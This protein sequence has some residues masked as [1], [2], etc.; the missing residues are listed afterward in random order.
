MPIIGHPS[1]TLFGQSSLFLSTRPLQI[2]SATRSQLL[3]TLFFFGRPRV[4]LRWQRRRTDRIVRT[5]F[6][7]GGHVGPTSDGY[8]LPIINRRGKGSRA[9]A[10]GDLAMGACRGEDGHL[11]MRACRGEDEVDSPV[12]AVP[13]HQTDRVSFGRLGRWRQRRVG[14]VA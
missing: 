12:L 7:H 8:W 11:A 13:R 14:D 4:F 5:S 6:G 9:P 3:T 1:F 10:N 2:T